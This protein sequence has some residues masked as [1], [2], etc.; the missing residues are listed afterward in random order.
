MAE[1]EATS[2]DE[3]DA[4]NSSM[5][6]YSPAGPD[7]LQ[8]SEIVLPLLDSLVRVAGSDATGGSALGIEFSG[9][10]FT[11]TRA[12]YMEAYDVPSGGDW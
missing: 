8:G 4:G 6:Y 9:L 11:E 7:A 3:N 5:L 1:G 10:Q 12:T 2:L